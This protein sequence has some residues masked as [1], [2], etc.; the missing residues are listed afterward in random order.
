[1]K[2]GS[3]PDRARPISSQTCSATSA[4]IS[5]PSRRSRPA[6]TPAAHFD[7][8]PVFDIAEVA[9]LKRDLPK[10]DV[11]VLDTGHFALDESAGEIAG[12]MRDFL[13]RL[14]HGAPK[15]TGPPY[16]IGGP[17]NLP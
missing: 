16:L 1:M 14:P 11:H 12:L 7:R 5:P 3:W 10:A 6:S 8:D 13:G 4:T 17:E 15:A 2:L 9:A